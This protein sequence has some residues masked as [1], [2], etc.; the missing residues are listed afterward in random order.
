MHTKFLTIILALVIGS[1]LPC[2]CQTN[3]A[4]PGTMSMH[5][6]GNL[7]FGPIKLRRD[8]EEARFSGQEKKD[9]EKE[10]AGAKGA[11]VGFSNNRL[12]DGSG[13][14]SSEGAIVY[15]IKSDSSDTSWFVTP[16][17]L[18][19]LEETEETTKDDIQEWEFRVPAAFEWDISRMGKFSILD[20]SL[21]PYLNTDFSWSH[22][23]VGVNLNM[24]YLGVIP[25]P[26]PFDAINKWSEVANT[27]VG[28]W[29]FRLTARPVLDYS[30][31]LDSGPHTSRTEDDDWFRIGANTGLEI[32]L[33][34]TNKAILTLGAMY[35][36]LETLDG[37]GGNSDYLR[38][39]V[40]YGISQYTSLT[41]EYQKGETPVADKDIDLI[42]IALEVKF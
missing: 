38:A 42:K 2:L 10:R 26:E 24:G 33:F 8:L 7:Q 6:K 32:G 41:F 3:I 22:K 39:Y 25:L 29:Q 17:T 31:V 37:D 35:R 14:W 4:F 20:V 36:F 34:G 5:E 28:S 19:K 21:E 1:N 30:D 12:I 40:S 15:N 9:P 11:T 18:W 27:G 16:A 23:I 13:A